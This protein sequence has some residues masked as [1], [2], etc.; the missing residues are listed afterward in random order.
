MSQEVLQLMK[1]MNRRNLELQLAMQCAPCLA[2]IKVSNLLIVPN[3]IASDVVKLFHN[4]NEVS[5]FVLGKTKEKTT[6][7]LFRRKELLDYLDTKEVK[8]LLFMLGYRIFNFDY[9]LHSLRIR[10]EKYM[11]DSISFPHEMGLLLGYP[12]EDVYGFIANKGQN[13]LL[14][15]YWKVYANVS[16]KQKMFEEYNRAKETM[17]RYVSNGTNIVELLEYY[18]K[19]KQKAAAI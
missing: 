12:A 11:K 2:G 1:S 15:G 17:I 5:F 6:F 7:L 19:A 3:D 4:N 10:Y 13:F 9:L 8:E 14:C 18:G 16:Q